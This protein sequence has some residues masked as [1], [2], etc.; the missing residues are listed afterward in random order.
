MG[1]RNQV[2][3]IED[4]AIDLWI[5]YGQDEALSEGWDL[6]IRSDDILEIEMCN[7]E[8][9][10]PDGWGESPFGLDDDVIHKLLTE[11][12]RHHL[13]ALYLEGRKEECITWLS[14]DFLRKI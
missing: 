5:K 4:K 1:L 9:D 3:S 12:K 13:L 6:F 14:P 8:E 11:K 2:L 10:W 7:N